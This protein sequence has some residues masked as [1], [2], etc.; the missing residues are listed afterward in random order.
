MHTRVVGMHLGKGF[1][2]TADLLEQEIQKHQRD[3][4]RVKAFLYC[5]PNNPLGVVYPRELTLQLMEVCSKHQVHFISDEIYALSVFD[6]SATFTSVLSI[7]REQLPDPGR[8]HLLWGLSKDFGLAGFRLGFIH[9]HSEELVRCLDGMNLY[10]CASVHIQQVP[11]GRVSDPGGRPPAGRPLLA[12]LR[13]L[14]RQ[15]R[16]ADHRLRH[17]EGEAGPPRRPRAGGPGRPLLLGGL[18]VVRG[19]ALPL[20]GHL[21]TLDTPGEMRLFRRLLDEAKVYMVPGSMFG[22][23]EPGWFRIIFAVSPDRWAAPG[24]TRRLEEGMDR[25]GALLAG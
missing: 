9:T 3:G 16:Q 6:Q 24:Y 22:C 21:D 25:L 5:N 14:P 12:G 17:G 4:G 8:T 10:T 18:Q 7:P 2:L 23:R 20:S 19:P 1:T 11:S 13:L 15:H